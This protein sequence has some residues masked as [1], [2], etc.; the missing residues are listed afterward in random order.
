MHLRTRDI[1]RLQCTNVE[2]LS[3][4]GPSPDGE[5]KSKVP[6]NRASYLEKTVQKWLRNRLFG[7]GLRVLRPC[8][9]LYSVVE[10]VC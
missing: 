4:A 9:T 10:Y 2:P 8:V 1:G 6:Q 5:D 3:E 7:Y